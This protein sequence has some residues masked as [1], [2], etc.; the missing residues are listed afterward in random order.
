[1]T[2]RQRAKHESIDER[3]IRAAKAETD[4][5]QVKLRFKNR[6]NGALM[7]QRNGSQAERNFAANAE[8]FG[9][10]VL[11][12]G[13]PDFLIWREKNGKTEARLIE[14]KAAKNEPLRPEQE[15]VHYVLEQAFGI[16]VEISH[17]ECTD[18]RHEMIPIENAGERKRKRKRDRR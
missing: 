10:R 18:I 11:H 14:V 16:G 17:G 13:W 4:W 6:P 8:R 3:L 5:R 2:Q 15:W 12:A 7:I 9:Y 1:M